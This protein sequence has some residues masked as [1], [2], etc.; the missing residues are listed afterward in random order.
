MTGVNPNGLGAAA[1]RALARFE[2]K[3]IIMTARNPSKASAVVEAIKIHYPKSSTRYE[4]IQLDLSSLSSVRE[5]AKEIQ[6]VAGSIDVLLNNAGVMAIPERTLSHDGIEMHLATNFLGHFLLTQLLL[7]QLLVAGKCG[8]ARVVNITSAGFVLTPFRFSDYN[9]DG[10]TELP[11]VEQ[12]NVAVAEAM[13]LTG[14]D[15]GSGYTPFLAYAQRNV[16][17]MLFTTGLSDKYGEAGV[18]GNCAAPGG[19]DLSLP[20]LKLR[21][22]LTMCQSWSLIFS[23]TFRLIFGTLTCSTR[24]RVKVSPVS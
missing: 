11:A 20:C 13:G 19:E 14:L 21:K 10:T 1:C 22:R 8:G 3:T 9:F 4:I 7:P 6:A 2:P 12:V 15:A 24:L 16:A 23:A 5:A 18:L 17:N